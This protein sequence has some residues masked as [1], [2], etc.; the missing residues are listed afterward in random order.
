MDVATGTWFKFLREDK[1]RPKHTITEISE[2]EAERLRD[3]VAEQGGIPNVNPEFDELFGG[4]GRMR[5]AFPMA[6]PDVRNI[7][8]LVTALKEQGWLPRR[9]LGMS[10]KPNIFSVNTVKQKLKRG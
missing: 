3:W 2:S 7:S 1:K 10:G 8:Q 6:S 5:V 9:Q 4:E